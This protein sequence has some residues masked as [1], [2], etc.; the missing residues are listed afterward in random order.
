M[1]SCFHFVST[2]ICDPRDCL[3]CYCWSWSFWR[4]RRPAVWISQEIGLLFFF[5][6]SISQFPFLFLSVTVASLF[7]NLPPKLPHYLLPPSL[8][9]LC[10]WDTFW[11]KQ[12]L[13]CTLYVV[14][15]GGQDTRS[16][17]Y[18]FWLIK[19]FLTVRL[20]LYFKVTIK[21]N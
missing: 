10:V 7:N 21:S 16:F 9:F 8:I 3:L 4:W 20:N 14:E 11:K 6:S 18:L 15:I 17:V 5:I 1:L 12:K 19:L 13:Y 2:R